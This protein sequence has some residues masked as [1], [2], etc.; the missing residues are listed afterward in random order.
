MQALMLAAGMGSRLG[1]FTKNNT[2]CML[3]VA[4]KKL[5]DR[6]IEAV[7]EAKINK[8]IIVVGYQ[9]QNL[10]E[11]IK[12]NYSNSGINFEFINNIDY[13]KSNNIY[14]FYLAK[15]YLLQDDT[16]LLESDLI[17]EK[18][19]IKQMVNN[20]EK[21]LVAV[22]KYESWMD[23]TVVTCDLNDNITKFISKIDM[24]IKFLSDYYKTVNVYKFSKEFLT[25]MYL[26]FLEAYIKAY[27]LNSYYETVL[28]VVAHIESS[29]L[30]AFYMNN[31]P[32]Y[33]IDDEQ[34]LDIA[35]IL[36]SKDKEK[37]NNIISKFGG[38]WRYNKMLD[39]CYLV[40]PY[41]PPKTMVEKLQNEYPVL[42]TQY[43]SGLAMQQMN[44]GRIF[45]VDKNKLLVGNGAAELINA[46]GI[47]LKGKVAVNLPTFNEYVRCFRD[48]QLISIDNSKNDYAFDL[49][50]LIKLIP[51]IDAMCIVNPDNPSGY[52]LSLEEIEQLCKEAQ[53]YNTKIVIDESFIDFANPQRKY[54]LLNDQIL[55]KYN[56]LIVIKSISKSYGVPALRLGVL[57]S[58]DVNLLNQIKNYM[59]VWNINSFAEYF[60][61][62]YN[63]FSKSYNDACMKIYKERE[64]FIQELS[65]IKTIK[66][67]QSEANY[68]MIDLKTINSYDF[69]VKMLN[70]YNILIKDLST[71]NYFKN[72]NFIRIAIRNTEENNIVLNAIL[73]E[74]Q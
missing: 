48:C 20:K 36:F 13:A 41:F 54:T 15:K 68:I 66:I 69:C 12:N 37:Y 27:G 74:L 23:G 55:D 38:Y 2:K 62:I 14:S 63:L 43:P 35:T 40:N 50:N 56:N 18:S 70:E 33:E 57:A 61:Q 52:M 34:D 11:Y 17:F 53:Q 21:N 19:L 8:F 9:G 25:N 5:I 49:S 72:K 39:F 60:L 64:R 47:V 10:I 46:L 51:E 28:K 58:S 67:Y 59:Q 29:S 22:A 42:L 1:K 6:A 45:N 44:A 31:M 30:K 16:I 3:E 65:K 4:G 26:P 24:N 71:K 32:W 73:N 7:L